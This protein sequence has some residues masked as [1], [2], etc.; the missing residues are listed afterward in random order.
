MSRVNGV[1]ELLE[2]RIA[3]GATIADA[4]RIWASAMMNPGH[5]FLRMNR[6]VQSRW[7]NPKTLG[8][9]KGRAWKICQGS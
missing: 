6:A 7:P 8:T 2:K 3:A 9:I 1:E 5:D 4:S